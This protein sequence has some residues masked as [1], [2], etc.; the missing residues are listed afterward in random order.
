MKLVKPDKRGRLC[1]RLIL[2]SVPE[3]MHAVINENGQVILTPILDL[4]QGF[5][6]IQKEGKDKK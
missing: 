4:E 3:Y 6:L 1:L 5:R 2:K